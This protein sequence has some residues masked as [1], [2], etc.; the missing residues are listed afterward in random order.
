MTKARFLVDENLAKR[1]IVE[2][3]R[4]HNTAIDILH[5]GDVGAPAEGTLDPEVLTYCMQTRRILVTGNRKSMPLH[6]AE[7]FSAGKHHWGMLKVRKGRERDIA[8]LVESLILIW[9]LEDAEAYL[10]REEWIPF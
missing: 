5:I 8:G 6:I 10:E 4:Q 2:G 1:A 7:I 3:V 9:E